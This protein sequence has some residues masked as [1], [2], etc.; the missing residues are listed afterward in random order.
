MMLFQK[1]IL[2][3][4]KM[5]K[6]VFGNSSSSDDNGNKIGSSMFVQKVHLRSN[7][8]ESNMEE[9]INLKNHLGVKNLPDPISIRE[10]A[11]KKQVDDKFNDPSIIKKHR[12]C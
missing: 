1:R 4:I 3:K 11:S 12:S 5:P 9:G 8:T 2:F 7:I 6:N 10:A